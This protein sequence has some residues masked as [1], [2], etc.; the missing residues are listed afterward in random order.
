MQGESEV[1][2]ATQGLEVFILL[3]Q[4]GQAQRAEVPWSPKRKDESGNLVTFDWTLETC[5]SVVN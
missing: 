1:R 3:L 5:S 4:C 2:Q